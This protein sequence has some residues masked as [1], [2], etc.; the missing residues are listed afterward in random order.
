MTGS[1]CCPPASY[2]AGCF[3]GTYCSAPADPELALDKAQGPAPP[4]AGGSLSAWPRTGRVSTWLSQPRPRVWLCGFGVPEPHCSQGRW[5]GVILGG[6]EACP[7]AWGG[8]CSGSAAAPLWSPRYCMYCTWIFPLQTPGGPP[9]PART[10][11]VG[12][13]ALLGPRRRQHR[14]P[15]RWHRQLTLCAPRVPS[16]CLW[17]VFYVGHQGIYSRSS[18][19]YTLDHCAA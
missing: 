11:A 1:G 4:P 10:T 3:P 16:P 9:S 12:V 18:S 19:P 17:P 15:P 8:L 7:P 13:P 2:L 6:A 14:C 5:Q